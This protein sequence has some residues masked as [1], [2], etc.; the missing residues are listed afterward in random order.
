[1]LAKV[2]QFRG[3]ALWFYLRSPIGIG[4]HVPRGTKQHN[5]TTG[6]G[7]VYN[8][9][10]MLADHA[11]PARYELPARVEPNAPIARPAL[12]IHAPRG[13]AARAIDDST[14]RFVDETRVGT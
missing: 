2:A 7:K 13:R 5:V 11:R 12:Y 8:V 3:H 6:R 4:R 10:K 14:E 1:M 9:E